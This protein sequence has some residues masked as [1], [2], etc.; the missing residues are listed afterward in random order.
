MMKDT[1]EKIRATRK[2]GMNTLLSDTP[3]ASMTMISLSALRRPAASSPPK[4]EAKGKERAM[5]E[6]MAYRRRRRTMRGSAWRAS[7][8]SA[9]YS[10]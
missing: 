1:P 5:K 9:M 3:E 4:S 10:T 2:K 7:I 6:G 8:C